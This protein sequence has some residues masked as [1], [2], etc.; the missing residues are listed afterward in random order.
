MSLFVKSDI[1]KKT[2]SEAV[3]LT[4]LREREEDESQVEDQLL[5]V[6][7]LFYFKFII[8]ILFSRWGDLLGR[9]GSTRTWPFTGESLT[10]RLAMIALLMHL[11]ESTEM[12][13]TT[14]PMTNKMTTKTTFR[15]EVKTMKNW[16]TQ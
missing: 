14:M 1:Y 16:I 11:V 15:S 12:M 7:R 5:K 3:T 6:G 13:S 4:I 10:V 9:T 8:I 2:N